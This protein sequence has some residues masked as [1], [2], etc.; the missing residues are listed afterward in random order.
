MA[1]SRIPFQSPPTAPIAKLFEATQN[2]DRRSLFQSKPG[3]LLNLDRFV[4]KYE[5][6]TFLIY[7]SGIYLNRPPG[8]RKCQVSV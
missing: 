1:Y 4:H 2:T 7:T 5:P 3:G 8:P 6:D